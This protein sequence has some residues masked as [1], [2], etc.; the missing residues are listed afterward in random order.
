MIKEIQAKSILHYH[1]EPI[2][3]NWDANIYRGCTHGCK[4]CFAQ[5]SH[6]YLE[7][8]NFFGNIYVKLNAGQLMAKEFAKRTWRGETV[9]ICGVT[10]CYQPIEAKYKLMPQ[11]L[12]ACIEAQNPV[13]IA[14]KSALPVRDIELIKE[15]NRVAGVSI[16]ASITTLNEDKRKLLEPGA[17]P[18]RERLDMLAQFAAAGCRTHVLL[19]P[20]IPYITYDKAELEDLFS[21]AQSAGVNGIV[22]GMLNLRGNTKKGF[23]NFLKEAYPDLLPKYTALYRGSYAAKPY[24]QQVYAFLGELRA[25]YRFKTYKRTLPD[26]RG[27]I[28]PLAVL[29]VLPAKSRVQNPS[30]AK[31]LG[32]VAPQKKSSARAIKQKEQLSLFPEDN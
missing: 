14:T 24:C 26:T 13:L 32:K 10:D 22:T 1:E 28:K 8:E 3:T 11:V 31:P 21:A 30:A 2:P 19:M 16:S 27:R 17:A 5:Y 6:D 15:L 7:E 9:N 12:R 25:K 18:A 20:I 4:Y 23:F 29:P